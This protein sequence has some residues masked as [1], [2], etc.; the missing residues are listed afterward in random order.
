MGTTEKP[1]QHKPKWAPPETVYVEFFDKA[2]SLATSEIKNKRPFEYYWHTTWLVN[3]RHQHQV[4]ANDG[5]ESRTKHPYYAEA[6]TA[7]PED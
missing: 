1:L 7:T 5:C 6:Q 4:A 3:D 2:S